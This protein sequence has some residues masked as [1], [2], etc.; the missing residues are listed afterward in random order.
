MEVSKIVCLE[1]SNKTRSFI[2]YECV[3]YLSINFTRTGRTKS[4]IVYLKNGDS[5]EGIDAW[6]TTVETFLGSDEEPQVTK[7]IGF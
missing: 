3:Q 7:K 1:K 6:F 4:A 2:P 5:I